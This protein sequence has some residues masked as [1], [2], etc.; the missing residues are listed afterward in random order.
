MN[1]VFPDDTEDKIDAIRNAIGRTVTFV[2]ISLTACDVCELDPITNTSLDSFC[3]HC[4][5]LYWVPVPS[6]YDVTAHITWGNAD[7]LNW[8][9]AGQMFD[10]DCRV[11]VK[12]TA[13]ITTVLEN[14]IE[15]V[16][17]DGQNFEIKSKIYRGVPTIN[18]ILI[19]LVE[20]GA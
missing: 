5:G 11:Q 9:T 6:G 18:R 1:I 2:T 13:A 16:E 12:S 20:K 15:R 19:D 8:A 17:V 7:I 3:I 10:G 4:S 14:E